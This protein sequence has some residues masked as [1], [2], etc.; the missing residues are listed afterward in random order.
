VSREAEGA[1][2]QE[3]RQAVDTVA[4]VSGVVAEQASQVTGEVSSV[5]V[6][7]VDDTKAQLRDRAETQFGHLA[8]DLDLLYRQTRAL[9]QGRV[10]DAGP[11][12]G[13]VD[14][15]ADQ[16]RDLAER[17]HD[18]GF[19]GVV[20]DI[21]RFARA[22]P[23]LFLSASAVA[24]VA[25]GRLLRNES[26]AVQARRAQRQSP[27]GETGGGSA[28]LGADAARESDPVSANR[29]SA[30]PDQEAGQ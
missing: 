8:E 26:A 2:A 17:V 20:A 7:L 29:V 19:D 30:A 4:E 22:R 15:G 1:V 12:V 23:V 3:V 11:L 6:R 27:H 25:I 5:A 10:D 28:E 18:R 14:E 9:A 21:K 16:L 13:Y 24:G